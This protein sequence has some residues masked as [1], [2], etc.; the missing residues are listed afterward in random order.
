[1]REGVPITIK[2]L[3]YCKTCMVSLHERHF[4]IHINVLGPQFTLSLPTCY[5]VEIA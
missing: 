4:V 5:G 1:M 2:N 3:F